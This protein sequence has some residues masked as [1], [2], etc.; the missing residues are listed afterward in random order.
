MYLRIISI[1]S[2]LF[3]ILSHS[4]NSSFQVKD[5]D[6]SWFKT[7]WHS[8]SE[9][10]MIFFTEGSGQVYTEIDIKKFEA[11]DTC[12]IGSSVPRKFQQTGDQ[13]IHAIAIQF[14][15]NYLGIE[16]MNL[17]YATSL[18]QNKNNLIDR[19]FFYTQNNFQNPITL[20]Q[21]AT[22]AC[23]SV[24]SFCLYFKRCT[25]KTYNEYLNE[26]RLNYACRQLRET[27]K[28]VADIGYESGY[29]TI[30]HFHRQ[31]LKLKKNT[32]LQYRKTL[33][34]Q[35]HTVKLKIPTQVI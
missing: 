25:H 29:N 13:V 6:N 35:Q 4:K 2:P 9:F 28:T 1:M 22:I 11:G 30:A 12:F 33:F 18:D 7:N 21:A 8:H 20:R 14:S 34:R 32:P 27:N 3:Q 16:F 23:M 17:L 19:I 24:P 26:V 31:F 5:V 15:D 10:E